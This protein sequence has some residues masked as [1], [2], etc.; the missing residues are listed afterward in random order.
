LKAVVW[1]K[2][3]WLTL[4][5]YFLINRCNRVKSATE[6]LKLCESIRDL[7]TGARI[8][9]W[10]A[11]VLLFLTSALYPSFGVNQGFYIGDQHERRKRE[12]G[13][14]R[15]AYLLE[16]STRYNESFFGPQTTL[17]DFKATLSTSADQFAI[18]PGYLK[19]EWEQDGRRYFEYAMDSPMVNFFNIMS[20]KL[21]VKTEMHNGVE[22]AVYYH[23]EHFWNVQR[24]I[25]SSKDS[26]DYFTQAFGPYQHKQLR[27]IE[28]PGYRSFALKFCQYS[29]LFGKYRFYYGPA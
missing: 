6:L 18:V 2:E 25:D 4:L 21:E 3:R 15:R 1:V 11:M 22:I 16:D 17:I 8:Q 12:L 14:P 27:I 23:R 13:P 7:K 29:A 28:Y 20:A 5:G 10:L 9:K 24:M 19:K 26:L